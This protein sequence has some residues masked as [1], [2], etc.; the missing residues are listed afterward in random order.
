MEVGMTIGSILKEF[1]NTYKEKKNKENL[2]NSSNP[3]QYLSSAFGG[4][5][6]DEV[7]IWCKNLETLFNGT[8]QTRDE[9]KAVI[10]ALVKYA[11]LAQVKTWIHESTFAETLHAIRSYLIAHRIAIIL[12]LQDDLK[13]AIDIQLRLKQEDNIRHDRAEN[14]SGDETKHYDALLFL[15]QRELAFFGNNKFYE[16]K[17]RWRDTELAF[18]R[19]KGLKTIYRYP[20]PESHGLSSHLPIILQ[21]FHKIFLA[22]MPLLKELVDK[23]ERLELVEQVRP[24]PI[25]T[26]S[27]VNNALAASPIDS[28]YIPTNTP[29]NTP[30]YVSSSS[31]SSSKPDF[32]RTYSNISA[33]SHN[34]IFS[35]FILDQL[36]PTSSVSEVN[37]D[38]QVL[39]D[40]GEEFSDSSPSMP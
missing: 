13:R 6:P 4:S 3:L 36:S 34:R 37:H 24:S 15:Y 10:Y 11:E 18:P 17:D 35:P 14:Y 39:Q 20:E 8:L 26:H 19:V 16:G 5:D 7:N 22:K 33:K 38:D 28:G 9:V 21:E 23:M 31:E 29:P 2:H 12:P 27:T 30:V 1:L 40:L 32:I 25:Y